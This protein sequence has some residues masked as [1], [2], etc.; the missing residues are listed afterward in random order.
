MRNHRF[1]PAI[2]LVAALGFAAAA[3]QAP[4]ISGTWSFSVDVGDSHGN[5]VFAF[6]QKGETLIGTATNPRGT[7]KVTGTVKNDRVV[8]GFEGPAFEAVY[9]GSIESPTRM[10]GTVEF[11]GELEGTGTW[12]ATRR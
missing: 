7:Q 4:D 10:R 6:E 1:G 8:F 9:T 3:A 11:S 12:V 5:P 2:V